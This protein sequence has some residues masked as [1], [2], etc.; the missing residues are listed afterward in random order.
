MKAFF[1][2][3]SL[4]IMDCFFLLLL[5]AKMKNRKMCAMKL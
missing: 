5:V 2:L 3:K 1:S 4:V